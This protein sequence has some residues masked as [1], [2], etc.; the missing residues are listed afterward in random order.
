MYKFFHEKLE[1]ILPTNQK[2]KQDNHYHEYEFRFN[3]IGGDQ[4][5]LTK[6]NYLKIFNHYKNSE[7]SMTNEVIVDSIYKPKIVEEF[8]KDRTFMYTPSGKK[9]Y[10]KKFM[11]KVTY[12]NI[13]ENFEENFNIHDFN[14]E[15]NKTF[16]QPVEYSL[17]EKI[18][19]H[20]RDH[21]KL[22]YNLETNLNSYVA[23]NVDNITM[24]HSSN[25]PSPYKLIRLK[26]RYTFQLDKYYKID[27]TMVQH[28]TPGQFKQKSQTE[29]IEYIVEMEMT[30][31]DDIAEMKKSL[32]KHLKIIMGLYF[33]LENYIFSIKPMNP[34]TLEQKDLILLKREEYSVTDKAD[35]ERMFLI[36]GKNKIFLKNPNSNDKEPWVWDNK[37][38]V[39]ETIIDGEYL[40]ETNEYLAFDILFY[41]SPNKRS[42]VDVRGENLKERIGFLKRMVNNYLK[43][44]DIDMKIKVKTFY[45]DIYEYAKNIWENRGEMF[46]Y[47][48]DG[49]IFTP[50]NQ[51]YT[52]NLDSIVNPVFKWKE[53]LSIDVRIGYI[54]KHNFTYFHFNNKWGKP[55]FKDPNINWGRWETTDQ[56]FICK[57]KTSRLNIGKIEINPKNKKETFSLGL[58]NYA[59]ANSEFNRIKNKDDI[60]EYEFNLERNRW[61]AIRIR[62]DKEKPNA[63]RTIGSI[64]DAIINY[65][66]LDDIFKLKKLKL[67]NIGALYDLTEDTVK[68]KNWRKFHNHVKGEILKKAS[69]ITETNYHLELACGKGGDLF[70]WQKLGYKNVLAIDTSSN[71]LYEKNGF[72]E[73]LICA[74][75]I[76]K[77]YY[78]KKKDMKITI[79]LGDVS[80]PLKSCGLNDEE[81]DKL[82]EFFKKLS[83]FKGFDTIAIQFSIH[84]M[85]GDYDDKTKPWNSKQKKL[86]GFMQNLKENLK[87]GGVVFGTYL[88]GRNIKNETNEFIH[89]GKPF[90]KIEHILNKKDNFK[91]YND[92]WENKKFNT[93]NIQNEVWGDDLKI[94]EPKINNTILDIVFKQYGL[95]NMNKNNSFEQYYNDFNNIKGLSLG[96]DEKRLSFINNVFFYSSFDIDTFV[97]NI[98]E[99][100][101]FNIFDKDTLVKELKINLNDYSQTDLKVIYKNLYLK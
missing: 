95:K 93:I 24:I 73:R 38:G 51:E 72:K 12:L 20:S 28:L 48:L 49:L 30:N 5:N 50:V 99:H 9:I 7:L 8:F 78:Y 6:E 40:H 84:Y 43:D 35:G 23:G 57:V 86:E 10:N 101:K 87:F 88:N 92:I 59:N 29:P 65:V 27:F 98:N 22:S 91:K 90:Y 33:K 71:E 36:F 17:K 70:K 46:N 79:V 67:E 3:E 60:V 62:N 85:F 54:H 75:F 66:S 1:K 31:V 44:I 11:K 82:K 100:F 74:G 4:L 39:H 42:Y 37:T 18:K 52:E 53:K 76:K 2:L 64:L 68:R 69:E 14:P 32:K 89:N 41:G 94:P 61:E 15:I 47:N 77:D 13:F 16:K 19:T 55:W 21:F 97:N 63:R 56:N 96:P 58:N 80:K 26:N 81:N 25:S 83:N 34:Q 45:Y